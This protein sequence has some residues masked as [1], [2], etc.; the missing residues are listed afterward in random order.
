[1]IFPA[2]VKIFTLVR[3]AKKASS[4]L[5]KLKPG[6][7]FFT[8]RAQDESA[9]TLVLCWSIL[10]NLEDED[11][12]RKMLMDLRNAATNRTHLPNLGNPKMQEARMISIKMHDWPNR[13]RAD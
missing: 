10:N 6:E 5:P 1:M 7:P 8:L 9:V 2:I 12:Y 3:L 13:K 11:D 4:Y